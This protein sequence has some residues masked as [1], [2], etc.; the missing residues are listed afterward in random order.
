VLRE[1]LARDPRPVPAELLWAH[2]PTNRLQYPWQAVGGAHPEEKELRRR[3]AWQALFMPQGALLAGRVDTNSWLTFG[4]REPLPVLADRR[5][6]LMAAEGVEA[7][8][9]YGCL[10]PAGTVG[11]NPAGE[12]AAG[13][14]A[15]A[16]AEKKAADKDKPEPPRVGWAALPTG[17]TLYLRQ[18]GLL[19]PEAAH[20][21][22]NT[23]WVTREGFGRGQVIL[24][25][26][27][28]TFR[29]ATRGTMRVF[30]NAVVYGPGLG[31]SHPLRP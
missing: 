7:P 25:A 5:S 4:C 27:P 2:Q 22:A 23:A 1:W 26:T 24:F 21:I 12:T 15:A 14:E 18:S 9:R 20:R 3:D 30:L 10:V 28:P 31:A 16:P 13:S 8:I 17:T 6:V 29:G 11:E 19:W